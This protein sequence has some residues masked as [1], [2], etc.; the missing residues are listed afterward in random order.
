MQGSRTASPPSGKSRPCA[1]G[2][3]G[4]ELSHPAMGHRVASPTPRGSP[5]HPLPQHGLSPLWFPEAEA[6]RKRGEE[7]AFS[8]AGTKDPLSRRCQGRAARGPQTTT[9]GVKSCLGCGPQAGTEDKCPHILQSSAHGTRARGMVCLSPALGSLWPAPSRMQVVS[10]P[11]SAWL[12][13]SAGRWPGLLPLV[14][15]GGLVVRPYP[16]PVPGLPAFP[17]G[18]SPGSDT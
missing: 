8:G 2:C 1:S 5:Q 3:Q 6:A 15:L 18:T 9:K 13:G 4:Q 11:G 16:L 10:A 7:A 17:T 14:P 12:E